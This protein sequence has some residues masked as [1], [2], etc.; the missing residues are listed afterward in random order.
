MNLQQGGFFIGKVRNMETATNIATKVIHL[1]EE[2]NWFW[3]N[4]DKAF[5][6]K[7]C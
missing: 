1:L 6:F 5:F 2:A 4:A 3:S 7:L